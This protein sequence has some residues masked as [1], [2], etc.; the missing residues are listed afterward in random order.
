ML[1]DC[2]GGGGGGG[3]GWGGRGRTDRGKLQMLAQ[4]S[5]RS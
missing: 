5:D 4:Q 1:R 2:P 3:G